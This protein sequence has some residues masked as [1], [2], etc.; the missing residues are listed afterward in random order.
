MDLNIQMMMN[1][2]LLIATSSRQ[3]AI[4]TETSKGI[5]E[6]AEL[7]ERITNSTIFNI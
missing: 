3:L 1:K 5:Q 4:R 7:I 6:W 2:G